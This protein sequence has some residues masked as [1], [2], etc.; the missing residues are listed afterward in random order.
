MLTIDSYIGKDDII[1]IV[2]CLDSVQEVTVECVSSPQPIKII[3]PQ[4]SK[5]GHW[6]EL[7]FVEDIETVTITITGVRKRYFSFDGF[8][9]K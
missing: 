9:R 7:K 1:E 2:Q 4:D 8:K 5:L 3:Q 6:N